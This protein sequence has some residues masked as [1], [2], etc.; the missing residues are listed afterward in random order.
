MPDHVEHADEEPPL[1]EEVE[2]IEGEVVDVLEDMAAILEGL[3][4]RARLPWLLQHYKRLPVLAL[5]AIINSGISIGLMS[6]IAYFTHSPFIFPSLGPTAFLF[7]YRPRSPSAT[8]R[9]AIIG[10]SIG[11]AAGYVS[12]LITGLTQAGTALQVGVTWP[13]IIA[14]T[15]AMSLTVGLMVLLRAP[16][17]PGAATT[18]IVALGVFRQF[19]QLPLLIVA[20]C[21]LTLQAIVIN[22][23]A[24]LNYPLWGSP[25]PLKN[26]TAAIAARKQKTDP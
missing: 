1:V 14:V 5:F 25:A 13:R 23:L 4:R 2:E 10:H 20:V 7:F 22:R 3:L 6:I 8:P 12:L 9:S 17:P 16:H 24:D 26:S 18:L 11:A 21:L 15:L 19:W